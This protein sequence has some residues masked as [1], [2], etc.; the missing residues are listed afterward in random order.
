MYNPDRKLFYLDTNKSKLLPDANIKAKLF[1]DR[2]NTVL[3]RTK[4]NFQ[5]KIASNQRDQLKL[6]TVDYLLTLS[7]ITLDRTL[8]LGSLIQAKEGKY[9]LEDP[10]GLVELDLTHAK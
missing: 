3:Q 1:L 8:I 9:F 7:Y 5:Q 6:Q 4:R 10:S 2:Y